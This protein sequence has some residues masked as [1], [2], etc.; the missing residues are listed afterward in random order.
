[1]LTQ[2]ELDAIKKQVRYEPETG[3]FY[4]LQ[5]KYLVR[6]FPE[7]MAAPKK[8]KLSHSAGERAD[9]QYGKVKPYIGVYVHLDTERHGPR[10]VNAAHLALYFLTGHWPE[11]VRFRNGDWG[12]LTASNLEP[13]TKSQQ[14]TVAATMRYEGSGR[15]LPP[16]VYGTSAGKYVGKVGNRK[17]REFESVREVLQ[18]IRLGRW[19]N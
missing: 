15:K 12:D 17:T 8:P 1:M 6:K 16:N 4:Y 18:A 13:R 2:I 7:Q 14:T 3:H 9:K 5:D 19:I 10:V 11:S